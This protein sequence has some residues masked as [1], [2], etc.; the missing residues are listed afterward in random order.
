MHSGEFDGEVY[1][2]QHLIDEVQSVLERARR[3]YSLTIGE[4]VGALEIIKHNSLQDALCDLE[5]GGDAY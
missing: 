2:I 1:R 4:L 5:D 3:E